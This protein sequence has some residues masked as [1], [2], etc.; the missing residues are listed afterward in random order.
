MQPQRNYTVDPPFLQLPRATEFRR[1][2]D[3][4]DDTLGAFSVEDK[5]PLKKRRG[6][7]FQN[8]PSTS[9]GTSRR[10][11]KTCDAGTAPTKLSS[12]VHA[13]NNTTA[14][15]PTDNIHSLRMSSATSAPSNPPDRSE[16]FLEIDLEALTYYPPEPANLH[17][18]QTAGMTSSRIHRRFRIGGVQ[19]KRVRFYDN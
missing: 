14:C 11:L 3:E 13:I 15:F 2:F 9:S 4:P 16:E 5:R 10:W 7:Y 18:S 19:K 1:E 8:S 17:E 6:G 12:E